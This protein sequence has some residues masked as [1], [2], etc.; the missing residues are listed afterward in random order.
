M[1]LTLTPAAT[2]PGESPRPSHPPTPPSRPKIQRISQPSR[3]GRHPRQRPLIPSA[4]TWDHL[5]LVPALKEAEPESYEYAETRD[6]FM[7]LLNSESAHA[8]QELQHVQ[9]SA[10]ALIM[11]ATEVLC[12]RRPVD[13]LASWVTPELYGAIQRRIL[14][15]QRVLGRPVDLTPPRVLRTRVQWTLTGACEAVALLSEGDRVRAAAA[16]LESKRGRWMLAALELA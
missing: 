9:R 6:S 15:A 11:A 4:E 12:G 5:R 14:L 8:Q 1:T 10:K 16:R 7:D 3:P 13:Q 2:E